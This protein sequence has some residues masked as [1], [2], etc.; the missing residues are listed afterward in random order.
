[1]APRGAPGLVLTPLQPPALPGGVGLPQT[2]PG[3]GSGAQDPP[4]KHIYSTRRGNN[5]PARTQRRHSGVFTVAGDDAQGSLW[6]VLVFFFLQKGTKCIGRSLRC[7]WCPP[8]ARILGWCG[9]TPH[10]VVVAHHALDV[11]EFVAQRL[12]LHLLGLVVGALKGG[13]RAGVSAH[14]LGLLWGGAAP[15]LTPSQVGWGWRRRSRPPVSTACRDIP[16]HI[17]AVP[18]FFFCPPPE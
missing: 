7:W 9:L 5:P 10:L 17:P 4:P 14:G 13:T 8:P 6:M 2:S 16:R 1:M 12:G 18:F 3:Q 11:E 15:S